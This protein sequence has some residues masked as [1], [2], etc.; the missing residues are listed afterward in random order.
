M[1]INT[2]PSLTS[3]PSE[4]ESRLADELDRITEQIQQGKKPDVSHLVNDYPDM[5]ET[6]HAYVRQIELLQ[7]AGGNDSNILGLAG[8]GSSASVADS[9]TDNSDP[10]ELRI[11]DYR[12]EHEIG[13]GG[14]G[15]VYAARQISLDRP[16][17]L[18]ILPFASSLDKMQITRFRNE[19]R[20]AGQLHHPNIVPVFAVGCEDEVHFYAMQKIVGE[21]LESVFRSQKGEAPGTDATPTWLDTSPD[22]PKSNSEIAK[23]DEPGENNPNK[24]SSQKAATVFAESN[25]WLKDSESGQS[26]DPDATASLPEQSPSTKRVK[27]TLHSGTMGISGIDKLDASGSTSASAKVFEFAEPTSVKYHRQIARVGIQVAEAL[28]YA[29]ECGIIHRD[30]KPSN[31]LLDRN[32][33]VWITDFG[34]ARVQSDAGL[35]QTG[36]VIGTVRYM[37]PEQASGD[38]TILDQRTDVYSL[39]ITLYELITL[40]EA[41]HGLDRREMLW[42][43]EEKDPI[44]PRRLNSSIP[45]DLE[46]IVLKAISKKTGATLCIGTGIGR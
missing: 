17:A 8:S 12:I 6:I 16:V 21:S 32:G 35:T 9:D 43:I 4:L 11:G 36:D 22:E 2:N 24:V 33:K 42:A 18:K 39:G 37:S 14:M 5:A 3:L 10:N 15:I 29:H 28:Q 30:I 40:H 23:I 25:D 20:A 31:L 44:T 1:R 38:L 13:R 45:I 7:G 19:A 46:T 27:E 26:F 41:F 34:L